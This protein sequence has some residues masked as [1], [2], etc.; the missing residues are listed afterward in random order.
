MPLHPLPKHLV[1]K[2]RRIHKHMGDR[3]L[4][5]YLE[6]LENLDPRA[7]SEHSGHEP[8]TLASFHVRKLDVHRTE[9]SI[10][11]GIAV[12]WSD[13]QPATLPIREIRRMVKDHNSKFR[14]TDY[15]VLT[16]IGYAIGKQLIAMAKVDAPTL[17]EIMSGTT[18]RSRKI[19]GKIYRNHKLN[20][21]KT[22]ELFI[23]A[24]RNLQ[25]GPHQ[26]L[27]L[28]IKNGKA[29]LLPLLDGM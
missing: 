4:F 27:F 9:P 14:P 24:S 20:G 22:R 2:L 17:S 25:I 10:K 26:I 19:T 7:H 28:G 1:Q 3:R 21:A 18:A 23:R 11:S 13:T 8:I 5:K 6:P 29:Q 15:E 12:K 16:P